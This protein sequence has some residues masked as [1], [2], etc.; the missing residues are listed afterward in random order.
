MSEIATPSTGD[1]VKDRETLERFAK[2]DELI[3]AGKCPN[4][5][6]DLTSEKPNE[7]RCPK[8]DFLYQVSRIF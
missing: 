2:N 5:C 3:Q 1:P 8:C 6:G 7:S 4:G